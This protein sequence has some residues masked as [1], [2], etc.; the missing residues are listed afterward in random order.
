MCKVLDP[1]KYDFD[2]FLECFTEADADM[3]T[4]PGGQNSDWHSYNPTSYVAFRDYKNHKGRTIWLWEQI[5]AR[6]G[7]NI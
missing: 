6:Y 4:V 2:K 3:H 7:S 1:E 5:T